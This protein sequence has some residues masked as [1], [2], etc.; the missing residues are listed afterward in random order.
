MF[1]CRQLGE[2]G[3]TG[4]VLIRAIIFQLAEIA[5]FKDLTAS[6]IDG[7]PPTTYLVHKLNKGAAEETLK[8]AWLLNI[9]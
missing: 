1:M 2:A 4:P 8:S 9:A 6:A 5:A 3:S 7:Y